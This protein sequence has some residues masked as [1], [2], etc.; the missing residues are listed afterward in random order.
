VH[1]T[2]LCVYLYLYPLLYFTLLLYFLHMDL[3]F[4]TVRPLL[5]GCICLC[6][7]AC[8]PVCLSVCLYIRHSVCVCVCPYL[9][10]YGF[11]IRLHHISQGSLA[12]ITNQRF[13]LKSLVGD[14]RKRTLSDATQPDKLL[15]LHH[16]SLKEGRV[17][18]YVAMKW[19]SN[20]TL[21]LQQGSGNVCTYESLNA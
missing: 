11:P 10:L 12:E 2:F 6:V 16:I 18:T 3:Y 7:W 8:V 17:C 15:Q 13:S 20:F 4:T 9:S 21:L 14:F 5:W 1:C 19:D